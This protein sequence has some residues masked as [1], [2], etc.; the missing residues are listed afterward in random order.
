MGKVFI[1]PSAHIAGEVKI[2]D[3]TKIW[4]N[5]QVRENASIGQN[6]NIGKDTYIDSGVIIGNG[7]KIQNGVSVYHGVILQDDVFI[8]PNVTFTNDF[9]PRAFSGNT[10]EVRP[11]LIKRGASIGANATIVCGHTLGQYC[12]VGAGS[13]VTKDVP[14]YT[15]AVG[16]P[17]RIIGFVCKCGQ[18]LDENGIC[19]KCGAE[20]DIKTLT[21]AAREK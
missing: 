7:C 10:W 2:G 19:R 11:T 13:T 12:M 18:K 8:G 16:N 9:Y 15:L 1:H 21:K 17:A 4:I 3:G 6:C 20:Y 14:P 5:S